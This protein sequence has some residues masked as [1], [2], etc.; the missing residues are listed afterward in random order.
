MVQSCTCLSLRGSQ[1]S[2]LPQRLQDAVG[3]H[4]RARLRIPRDLPLLHDFGLR[5][6]VQIVIADRRVNQLRSLSFLLGEDF[7]SLASRFQ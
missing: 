7:S 4:E 2:S 6:L 5:V 3:L 1:L